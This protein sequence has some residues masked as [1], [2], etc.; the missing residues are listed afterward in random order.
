MQ[1]GA[2]ASL[3]WTIYTSNNPTAVAVVAATETVI[4]ATV[5]GENYA[6]IKFTANVG[7]SIAYVDVSQVAA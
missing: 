5:E 2:F 7:G 1:A 4:K 6:I 3:A